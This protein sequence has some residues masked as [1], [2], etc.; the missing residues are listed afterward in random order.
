MLLRRLAPLQLSLVDEASKLVYLSIFKALCS[1]YAARRGDIKDFGE[2]IDRGEAGVSYLE[3][4]YG[5]AVVDDDE[6][7]SRGDGDGESDE[8]YVAI[9]VNNIIW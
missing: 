8:A 9:S 6:V 4:A 2:A 5:L 3:G 7:P 1:L